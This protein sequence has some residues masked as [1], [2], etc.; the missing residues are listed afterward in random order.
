M[1]IREVKNDLL[2][3]SYFEI[4]HDSGLR[5][6]VYPKEGYSSTFAIFGTDYGSVDADGIP[7][8]TAHFLEHKLFESDEI[9]AFK[10]FAE[11]GASA[12]AYTTF[13]RTCYLFNCGANFAENLGILLDFVTHPYF[14]QETV[15]KEQGI[16]GQEIKMYEDDPMWRSLFNLLKAAYKN[17]PVRVDLAGTVESI[18]EITAD[19]LYDCY[20]KFYSLSNM[21]LACVGNTTVEEVLEVADRVLPGK[22]P[23]GEPIKR[24]FDEPYEICEKY[25]EE[26]MSVAIPQFALGFKLA[27]GSD[28]G[29]RPEV[30]EKIITAVVL[31]CILGS[32]T[33]FYN[34]L[35]RD[36]YISPGFGAEFFAGPGSKLLLFMGD[37]KDPKYVAEAIKKQIAK[38]KETGIPKEDFERTRKAHYGLAVMDFND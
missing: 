4:E 38:V 15:E 9:D 34:E 27:Q 36:G 18:A 13:D 6:F 5:I 28:T 7:N 23:K 3:D 35:L 16:I 8:G 21:A 1:N 24:S 31:D 29:A 33:E 11:T 30:R 17:H 20:N 14:T 22:A 2:R 10:R 37:S 19:T 32:T 26:K 25:V 12:N